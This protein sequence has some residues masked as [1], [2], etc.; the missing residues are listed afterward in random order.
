MVN[1]EIVNIPSYELRP[2]DV[3]SVRP[4]SREL[5]VIQENVQR[6]RRNFTWLE[7]DREKMKGKFI[8]YPERQ[9]IPENIEEQLI[10]ELYSK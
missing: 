5:E 3:V 1:D 9:D 6:H 2:D 10:V 4:K 7:V 8:D